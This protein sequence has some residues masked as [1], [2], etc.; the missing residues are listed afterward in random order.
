MNLIKIFLLATCVFAM[1][2]VAPETGCAQNLFVSGYQSGNI[3]Q[4]TPSGMQ[5][6]FASGLNGP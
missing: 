4:F 6:G 5:M 1:W 2:L 3:Y